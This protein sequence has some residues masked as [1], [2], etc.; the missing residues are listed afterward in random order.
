MAT[1]SLTRTQWSS[2]LD[3]LL[4]T[5]G[6]V[7]GLGNIFNFPFLA[8]KFGGMFL[9]FYILS[10][11]LIGI[12]IFLAELIIGRH[13][14]INP[15]MGIYLLA[16][17]SESQ[18]PWHYIGWLCFA[19]L[20]SVV[21]YYGIEAAYPLA[22][23]AT[24]LT[25]IVQNID[26]GASLASTLTNHAT[27]L[28]GFFLVFI[29][30]IFLITAR[31][32]NKGL[33]TICR[34]VVP[35]VF[36]IM[37]FLAIYSCS[38]GNTKAAVTALFG[39]AQHSF[40]F[41]VM[42]AAFTYAFFKLN[43]GMGCMIVYGSYLPLT[44][45]LGRSAIIIAIMDGVFSLLAYFTLAPLLLLVT[46]GQSLGNFAYQAIPKLFAAT[47]SHMLFTQLFFLATVLAAW[48]P[49][50]AMAET[51]TVIITEVFKLSRQ[52]ATAILATAVALV[53]VIII[54]FSSPSFTFTFAHY[55]N[56][57]TIIEAISS[58][59]LVPISAM[60][61]AA[62]VGWIMHTNITETE[63]GFSRSIYSIWLFL[64]RIVAP[65]GI[66]ALMLNWFLSKI[67]TLC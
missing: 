60:L 66:I 20:F 45:K 6:A 14:K 46:H 37:L 54:I 26:Y 3:Y 31:G 40:N 58:N 9:L 27:L 13:G 28:A 33:E 34:V 7:I 47:E 21:C 59:I 8:L 51:M 39:Y 43:V 15:V 64:I 42:F 41:G 22:Y 30:V 17:E 38:V 53:G 56:L 1:E 55:H 2:G 10:E 62:F 36:V 35:G 19:I 49:T 4:V 29:A 16:I 63:L 12:P 32:I 52:K 5:T 23:A 25:S 18:F 24:S 61:I 67:C 48:M 44:V 57:R 65:F 11:L 50:I